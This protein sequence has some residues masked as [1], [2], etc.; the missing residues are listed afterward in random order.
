MLQLLFY[1]HGNNGPV[2]DELRRLTDERPKASARLE[3]DLD[4]LL[5]EGLRSSRII[6]R[7]LGSKLWELK[8]SYDGIEYRLFL[9]VS[10]GTVWLL[11]FI[12]KKS[13]K[14]PKGDLHLARKR[15]KE[16]ARAKGI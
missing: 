9:G 3:L 5:M 16:V 15:L 1:P 10:K 6:I 2:R 14:T 8:R 4:I 11:H 7:P 12:E 13:A